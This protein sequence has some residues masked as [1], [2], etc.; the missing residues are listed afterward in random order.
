MQQKKTNEVVCP[1]CVCGAMQT[2][3]SHA[4]QPNRRNWQRG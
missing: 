4:V 1:L 3:D 2:D